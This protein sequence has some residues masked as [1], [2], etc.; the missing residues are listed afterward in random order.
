MLLW[1]RLNSQN[2]IAENTNSE[3]YGDLMEDQRKG[4][5]KS[6]L[7]WPAHMLTCSLHALSH[8]LVTVPVH[9]Q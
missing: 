4:E 9:W 2:S 6:E 8:V 5:R 3:A 7:T 1:N